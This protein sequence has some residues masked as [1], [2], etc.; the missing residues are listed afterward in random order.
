LRVIAEGL[1]GTR[2]CSRI[3]GDL[4]DPDGLEEAEVFLEA[5]E[6][7]PTDK[8]ACFGNHDHQSGEADGA[9]VFS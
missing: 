9:R 4:T 5:L 8:S 7:A 2:T 1:R 6:G 3:G